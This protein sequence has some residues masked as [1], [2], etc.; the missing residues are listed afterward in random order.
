MKAY[1]PPSSVTAVA[2]DTP[3]SV[4]VT[5]GRPMFSTVTVPITLA[6]R[7]YA[8]VK[9]TVTLWPADEIVAAAE[10]ASNVASD[11]KPLMVTVYAPPST[12]S[13]R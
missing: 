12:L 8:P 4:T 2:S 1:W 3:A 7:M 5:P 10:V 6:V 11:G 9:L 13:K